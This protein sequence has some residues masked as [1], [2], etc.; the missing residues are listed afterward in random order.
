MININFSL[1]RIFY[2]DP[3]QDRQFYGV[4]AVF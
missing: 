2:T 4:S 1:D 3:D